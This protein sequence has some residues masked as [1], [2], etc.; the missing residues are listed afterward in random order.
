MVVAISRGQVTPGQQDRLHTAVDAIVEATLQDE[1]CIAYAF[2]TDIRDKDA[3]ICVEEWRDQNA[4]D[5]HQNH[6]HTADF[7][8]AASEIFEQTT[9]TATY[10]PT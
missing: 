4:L 6:D 1:G 7:L 8:K 9:E 5:T 3:V 10:R 2:F